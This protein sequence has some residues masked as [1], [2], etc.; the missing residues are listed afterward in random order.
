MAVPEFQLPSGAKLPQL[1]YGTGTLWIKENEADIDRPTVDGIKLAIELGYRHLDGAQY[2]KTE[3]ELGVAV[4]ESGV[5]RSEFFISTK[6]IS[7][8]D[9]EGSL[10][11]SLQKLGM[12]YVDLYL[13]H[14]PFSAG[15]NEQVLQDAW[16]GMEGCLEK[17]LARN[18]GVSNFLIPHLDA[19]LKIAKVKPMVNQVELHPYLQRTQLVDYLKA[20]DIAIEAYAP[21]GPLVKARPGPIDDVTAR[22]A[23]KYAVSESVILLRWVIQLGIVVITTSGRKER[24]QEYLKQV[25]SFQLTDAEVQE[26][27]AEGKKKNYRAFFADAYGKDCFD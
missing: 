6:A 26:I 4:K 22:L 20:Q 7:P 12:D 11:T 9:V 10:R 21:L 8:V 3:A 18:I 17:G 13:I 1:A 15:G 5:P 2:Y 25:P 24:L 14:E 23:E 27:S 16:R 19:V